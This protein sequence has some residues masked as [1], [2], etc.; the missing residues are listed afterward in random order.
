MNKKLVLYHS[1]CQD[2]FCGA[3]LCY[4]AWPNAEFIPV[5]YNSE[6]PDVTGRDVLIVDFSY[7]RATTLAMNASA[8][9]LTVLDHHESAKNDLVDL[10]HFCT[11]DMEKSGA[12]LTWDYLMDHGYLH[13]WNFTTKYEAGYIHWLV[14]YVEDRDLWRWALPDSKAINAAIRNYPLDFKIWDTLATEPL[15]RFITEGRPL[16]TFQQQLIDHHLNHLETIEIGGLKG[17]GCTCAIPKI[18]SELMD[19]LLA[20]HTE[21]QFAAVWL[22]TTT[23]QRIYSL[24]SRKDGPNIATLAL[25]YP[26]GG[27]HAHAGGFTIDYDT[28]LTARTE[29]PVPNHGSS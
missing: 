5:N 12:R 23:K 27:G 20:K 16:L 19:Q 10:D 11:F 22:D 8:A 6:P 17:K 21:C 7:P 18:W 9:A 29:F 14:K 13:R 15:T 28:K 25:N 1:S 26:G 3:W 2:G 4:R 24:R